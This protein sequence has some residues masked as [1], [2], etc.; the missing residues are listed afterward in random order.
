VAEAG[1]RHGE[2][3]EEAK[4]HHPVISTDLPRI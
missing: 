4:F 3:R 1:E 2:H